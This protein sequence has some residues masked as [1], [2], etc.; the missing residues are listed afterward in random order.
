MVAYDFGGAEFPKAE[1]LTV[2]DNVPKKEWEIWMK[3]WIQEG[4]MLKYSYIEADLR[5]PISLPYASYIHCAQTLRYGPKEKGW[6]KGDVIRDPDLG[7][8]NMVGNIYVNL[9]KGGVIELFDYLALVDDASEILIKAGCK[10]VV[11]YCINSFE[12]DDNEV[13]DE[14]RVLL[15][16]VS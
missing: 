13:D 7:F 3:T 1:V 14:W 16:K 2:V 15:V 6:S 11:R 12:D 9:E 4:E 8:I 10:E 5:Q